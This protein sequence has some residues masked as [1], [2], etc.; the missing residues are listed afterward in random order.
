MVEPQRSSI[1]QLRSEPSDRNHSDF[2]SPTL[3]RLCYWN[4]QAIFQEANNYANVETNSADFM[5]FSKKKKKNQKYV[6]PTLSFIAKQPFFCG[7]V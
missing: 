5:K 4:L 6:T 3:D 7:S 1:A 2:L